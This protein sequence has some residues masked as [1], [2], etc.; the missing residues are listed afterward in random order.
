[1]K[2]FRNRNILNTLWNISDTFLYPVL[3][4]GSTSFFIRKLGTEQFGIWMLINTVVVTM[5]L[6][7]LGIGS[8]VF[9]NI[10]YYTAQGNGTAKNVVMNNAI[11][12]TTVLFGL[13]ICLAG[14]G[15]WLVYSHNLLHVDASFR[16]I[17]AQGILLAGIIVGLR[18]FEQAITAYFK[19]MER[20]SKAMV[21][22][23]GNK[24]LALLLNIILI[25]FLPLNILHLLA[26]I[27]VI[28]ILFFLNSLR[29]LRSDLQDFRFVFD[30]KLPRQDAGFA[31]V[32]WLQSLVVILTFQADRYLAVNYFGLTVLGYYALT[33]TIFNHLHMGMQALLPWLAPKLTK[34]YARNADSTDLYIAARNLVAIASVVLLIVLYLLYPFIFKIVLG[35]ETA[36]HIFNYT[37]FFIVFELFFALNIIPNYYFNAVGHERKYFWFILFFS[38]TVLLS[39]GICLAIFH[40]PLGILYGLSIGCFLSMLVQYLLLSRLTKGRIDWLGSVG[41][42]T[43]ASA[44]ALFIILPDRH[45]SWLS[46]A[47][48][49]VLLYYIYIR[50]NY[51]RFKLLLRS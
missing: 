39:M 36:L 14:I 43:P 22:S 19:A 23:S 37:R 25:S 44:I 3:F 10:A 38:A 27:I 26:I 50:G 11:S 1:M 7:N 34:L 9:R 41:L 4:F 13:S 46:F 17:C 40:G 21:I 16:T 2:F 20:F 48:G 5:Q 28:N 18:F 32:T 35:K 45:L 31:M 33:A 12:I 8:S 6:F 30:L 49:L 15:G 24:T 29:M 47:A 42:L 51:S